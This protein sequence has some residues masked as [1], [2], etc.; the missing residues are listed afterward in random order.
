MYTLEG[1]FEKWLWFLRADVD[2]FV[3]FW[4]A[5]FVRV[6]GTVGN[7]VALQFFFNAG[8]VIASEQ[9]G[10]APVDVVEISDKELLIGKN[11]Q[12]SEQL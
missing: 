10:S 3:G 6:V 2:D 12:L 7:S 4:T 11:K 9:E 8:A 1:R 5:G